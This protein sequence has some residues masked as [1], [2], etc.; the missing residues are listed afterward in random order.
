MKGLLERI[1]AECGGDGRRA[2]WE[3]E[4][5]RK[6]GGVWKRHTLVLATP[7]AA[8]GKR[9]TLDRPLLAVVAPP[10]DWPV[11]VEYFHADPAERTGYKHQAGRDPNAAHDDNPP[12]IDDETELERLVRWLFD[13]RHADETKATLASVQLPA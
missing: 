11:T 8:P 7:D 10:S 9:P 3:L 2:A 4:H 5:V 1:A 6:K 13:E 12:T